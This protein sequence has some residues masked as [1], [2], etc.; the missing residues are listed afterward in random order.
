K[1]LLEQHQG[2]EIPPGVPHQFRNESSSDVSFLVISVPRS[3]GDRYI[4]EL[5]AGLQG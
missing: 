4:A 3:H 5:P 1:V 2:V